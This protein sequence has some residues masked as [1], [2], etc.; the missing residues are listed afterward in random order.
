MTRWQQV[1][2]YLYMDQLYDSVGLVKGHVGRMMDE[3]VVHGKKPTG[4]EGPVGFD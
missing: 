3:S 4:A 1:K 2:I